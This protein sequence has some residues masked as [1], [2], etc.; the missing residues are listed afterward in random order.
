MM[1]SVHHIDSADRSLRD[2]FKNDK[3]FGGVTVVFGGD[4]RQILPIICHGN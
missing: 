2:I 4:P 1:S 3:P